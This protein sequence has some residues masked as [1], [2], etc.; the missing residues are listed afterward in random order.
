MG[1][2]V[3]KPVDPKEDEITYTDSRDWKDWGAD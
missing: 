2:D 3:R 1:R